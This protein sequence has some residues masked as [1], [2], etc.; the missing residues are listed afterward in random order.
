MSALYKNARFFASMSACENC[1]SV[2]PEAVGSGSPMI[3]SAYDPM[4][5]FDGNAAMYALSD[6]SDKLPLSIASVL[7]DPQG[8]GELSEVAI[9]VKFF[10]FSRAAELT[11]NSPFK[12]G[13]P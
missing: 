7:S 13:M 2:F 5:E 3:T 1:Q 4:L 9:S 12:V 11:W 10:R 6:E 8:P